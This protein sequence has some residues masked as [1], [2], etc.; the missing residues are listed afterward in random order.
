[1]LT[2]SG[3]MQQK[4]ILARWLVLEPGILL[5]DEPTRGVDIATRRSIYALLRHF[6]AQGVACVV[7]SSD[8]EEIIGLAD[9]IV[10]LSDGTTVTD[11][12]S[13]LVD[14]EKLTMFAAPRSSAERTH[15]VLTALV[16]EFGGTAY[17]IATEAD[18]LY[19]FD[20]VCDD[21]AADPGFTS[22]G[23]PLVED[24]AIPHALRAQSDCL[25]RDETLHTLLTP[26]HGRRGHS[27][28]LVGV[29]L[30]EPPPGFDAAALRTRIGAMLS[31]S[32]E[33][34]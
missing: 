28:G 26:I 34:V 7:V 23:F 22:G 10:V 33:A 13:H 3:G 15:G 19:C 27:L 4:V 30:S 20:F 29:T 21:P 9:R 2:F 24:T 31:V 1:M 12:P 5:L 25:V 17:W 6:A 8:F 11:I 14:I 32:A 18:R 16:G